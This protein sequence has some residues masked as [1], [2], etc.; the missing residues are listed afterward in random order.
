MH[1]VQFSESLPHSILFICHL[2]LSRRS[3]ITCKYLRQNFSLPQT[4]IHS[5]RVRDR[6]RK[7]VFLMLTFTSQR[8]PQELSFFTGL[9]I[10]KQWIASSFYRYGQPTLR[11]IYLATLRHSIRMCIYAHIWLSIKVILFDTFTFDQIWLCLV[12][13]SVEIIPNSFKILPEG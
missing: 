10:L 4:L 6:E 1:K 3:F 13:K 11:S 2:S 12:P 5:F 7:K 8:L 9:I